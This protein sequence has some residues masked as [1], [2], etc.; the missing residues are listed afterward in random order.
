MLK[1]LL[2]KRVISCI[3]CISI[4][5]SSL[6][7]TNPKIAAAVISKN[8]STNY[9]SEVNPMD[10]SVIFAATYIDELKSIKGL[11][12]HDNFI[13]ADVYIR[14]DDSLEFVLL[15]KTQAK[16]VDISVEK[17]IN[18]LDIRVV[19]HTTNEKLLK[20]DIITIEKS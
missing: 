17:F 12:E 10:D 3:L 14:Q 2:L 5:G 6:S 13:S 1:K 8:E 20:S 7:V 18:F 4:I 11:W 19:I 15:T 16:E 9:S